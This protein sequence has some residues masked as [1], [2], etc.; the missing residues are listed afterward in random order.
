MP[1][2]GNMKIQKVLDITPKAIL[3]NFSNI[4]ECIDNFIIKEKDFTYLCEINGYLCFNSGISKYNF[5]NLNELNEAIAQENLED[6]YIWSI[7]VDVTKKSNN[8]NQYNPGE[9]VLKATFEF[10]DRNLVSMGISEVNFTR[11]NQLIQLVANA[12][13][14]KIYVPPKIDIAETNRKKLIKDRLK[15][16]NKC[17][18]I[19]KN[20]PE[21]QS[22]IHKEF[23]SEEDVQD[24]IYPILKSHFSNLQYEDYTPKMGVVASKPDFCIKSLGI[25]IEIKYINNSKT[26]KGLTREINDD[27][28]KY[29]VKGSPYTRMIVFIY[30]GA[31][32]PTPANF[33]SDFE[34]IE[35]IS[36]VVISPN[37]IPS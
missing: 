5:S 34:N 14:C 3:Q 26:F 19:F 33:I 17:V 12:L 30:N 36:S 15:A 37:I 21:L 28:R 8:N 27:S 1:Y 16:V 11:G 23:C 10:Y 9:H 35:E 13:K 7:G 4:F 32:K 6:L 24:F 31:S 20:L 2:N 29:F 18:G 25:A 22:R